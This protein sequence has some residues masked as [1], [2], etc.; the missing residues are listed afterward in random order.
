MSVLNVVCCQVEV[1]ATDWSLV[2]R[3]PTDCG[4]SLCVIKKHRT[5]KEPKARYRAVQIQPLWIVTP[6]KQITTTTRSLIFI[7]DPQNYHRCSVYRDFS[8]WNICLKTMFQLNSPSQSSGHMMYHD[9]GR[10]LCNDGEH[11]RSIT[12]SHPTTSYHPIFNFPK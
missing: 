5:I 6:G 12:A 3:S 11:L 7:S 9:G 2:Q 4:A 10:L 1:S 8:F